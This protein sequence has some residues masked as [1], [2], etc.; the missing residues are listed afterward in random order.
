MNK[1]ENNDVD[2]FKTLLTLWEA[3]KLLSIII[4]AAF[5]LG[6]GL[7]YSKTPNYTS[8]IKIITKKNP[9]IFNSFVIA[10]S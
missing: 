8:S 9:I 3:K 5:L 2:L 4:I 6:I 7:V 10:L 1:I